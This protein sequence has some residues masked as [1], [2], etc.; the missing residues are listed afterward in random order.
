MLKRLLGYHLPSLLQMIELLSPAARFGVPGHLDFLKPEL[1]SA[2]GSLKRDPCVHQVFS[3]VPKSL[4][5]LGL[6]S[7]P[8]VVGS[9]S[10]TS[11]FSAA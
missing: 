4:V 8:K 7:V 5:G 10:S 9:V 6:S 2:G 1:I 3:G 11:I